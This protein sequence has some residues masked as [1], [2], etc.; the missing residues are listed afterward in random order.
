[1]AL[2]RYTTITLAILLFILPL[3]TSVFGQI[4]FT[5]TIKKPKEFENRVLRSEKSDKKKFSVP[6]RLIQNTVTHYNYVFNANN[7]LKEILDRA[8]LSFTDDFSQLIPFYNYTLDATAADSIQLDS[9]AQK[10]QTGIVLHDLRNDWVDNLYVLWGASYYFKQQFDSAY[11]MFQFINYAFAE[12]EKDGYYRTIGSARDG[13]NAINISTKEKSSLPRKVFAEP[14]SRNDAFVWQIRNYLAQDRFSEASSLIAALKNDPNFPSRLQNDLEEVQAYSFYKQQMW[15]SAAAHLENALSAAVSQ[16]EKAR[17]EFLLGQLHEMTGKY[18]EAEDFYSKSIGHTTDLIMDVYA[19]L[20]LVRVNKDGG[21]NYIENNIASLLKMG[22]RDKY[23]DYRDIIYYMAAQMELERKNPDAAYELLLKSTKYTANNPSQRNKAFLQL[24]ELA[25]DKKKYRQSYNFY[26]SVQ[27]GDPALKNP[28]AIMARKEILAK[29]A[30][31]MEII[32]RQDSLQKIAAMPEDERKSL[33]KKLVRQ[34]RKAQGL[35]DEDIITSP[36]G[37]AFK[38][39]EPPALFANNNKKGEWYFYNKTSKERGKTEF[40]AKWGKRANADNWRRSNALSSGRNI[41]SSEQS[42]ISNATRVATP[43]DEEITFESLNDKLPLTQEKMSESNDSIQ[44]AQ[45]ELAMIYIKELEDCSSGTQSLEDLRSRFPEHSK[46]EEILFNLYYCFHK[47]GENEKAAAIKKLMESKFAGN[48]LTNIVSTGKGPEVNV[49]ELPVTKTYEKIYDLFIEGNFTEAIEQKRVADSIYGNNHWTPQLLYIEAVYY[50]K[51]R[52]DSLATIALNNIITKFEGSPL[53]IKSTNLLNVLSRRQEIEEELRSMVIN[54]P[55]TTTSTN[56]VPTIITPPPVIKQPAAKDTAI[57]KTIQQPPVTINKPVTDTV[58]KQPIKPEP[59]PTSY[60][61]DA[62]KPHYVV[63]VLNKIDPIFVNEA[64]N[65][66][67]RYNKDTYF[68]KL[69]QA[70][71]IDIDNENK[72]LLISPFKNA[73]E[74]TAYVDQT[75][76]RTANE[77][78]PWLKGGKYTY[79]IITERNLEVLKN[80]KDIDKYKQFLDK[81]IPGKF[82]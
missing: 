53:A 57:S 74:A 43:E 14:P 35:K 16:G 79:S 82:Q 51:E 12:K 77:I 62:E 31:N 56:Q 19:R 18:K 34:L 21:E 28:E 24:A 26:D 76:P 27:I 67:A 5:P 25:F 42:A 45:F 81:N 15:D 58:T 46:M 50:I 30:G 49:Q 47:H 52:Q 65:A 69:M 59:V 54:M 66:F 60:S 8:K 9:I 36:A 6:K 75:K 44:T 48:S 3:T 72:L 40:E 37:N 23:V 41:T 7:K 22:K 70:E 71:L 2:T 32:E 29:L 39:K 55:D 20:A 1:M 13:N 11:L 68:N 4:G 80:S 33:I 78:V 10:A 38:Q 73:T 64:K 17:W 61:F 63:I